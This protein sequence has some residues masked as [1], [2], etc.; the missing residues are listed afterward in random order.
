MIWFSTADGGMRQAVRSERSQLVTEIRGESRARYKVVQAD[1]GWRR[2]LHN[3]YLFEII[4]D[5]NRTQCSLTDGT[6]SCHIPQTLF[7]VT[8]MRNSH[9]I[10]LFSGI[11]KSVVPSPTDTELRSDT[12][13]RLWGIYKL[14]AQNLSKV[15][16]GKHA[17]LW[18]CNW[19][20]GASRIWSS[21]GSVSSSGM[22]RYSN[23]LQGR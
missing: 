14:L 20:A 8:S 16:E 17:T 19:S 22:N 21:C 7:I 10:F 12:E 15:S 9:L 13:Y 1:F 5:W 6:K 11:M 4:V 23:P 18:T 2:C 3:T